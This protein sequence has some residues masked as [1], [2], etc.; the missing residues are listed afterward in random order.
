MRL[1]ERSCAERGPP[2]AL[3]LRR[4]ARGHAA[5]AVQ[6]AATPLPQPLPDRQHACSAPRACCRVGAVPGCGLSNARGCVG[7]HQTIPRPFE[8]AWQLRAQWQ[9]Q[10]WC[11]QHS[12]SCGVG[13][14]RCDCRPAPAPQ[15][16][17]RCHCTP[18]PWLAPSA[19]PPLHAEPHAACLLAWGARLPWMCTASNRTPG[20][21]H[22]VAGGRGAARAAAA[23]SA[24]GPPATAAPPQSQSA[25]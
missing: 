6:P 12:S 22:P 19:A 20:L 15:P 5:P 25:V 16:R 11:R 13:P 14:L 4:R 23:R 17:M 3:W 9:S 10:Q 8:L 2:L 18:P 1:A 7:G 21:V 24:R